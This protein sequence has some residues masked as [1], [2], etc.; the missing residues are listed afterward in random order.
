MPETL[1]VNSVCFAPVAGSVNSPSL[2]DPALGLDPLA[3]AGQVAV[4]VAVDVEDVVG[5]GVG[6]ALVQH[7]PDAFLG[8]RAEEG[9][10]VQRAPWRRRPAP[11][12]WRGPP[13]PGQASRRRALSGGSAT[14]RQGRMRWMSFASVR[15]PGEGATSLF[16]PIL[17]RRTPSG[18]PTATPEGDFTHTKERWQRLSPTTRRRRSPSTSPR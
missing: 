3:G 13:E 8:L 1:T 6:L 17:P 12:G 10:A 18:A 2:N 7:Q 15:P 4:R 5:G 9:E 14:G 16:Q 11:S